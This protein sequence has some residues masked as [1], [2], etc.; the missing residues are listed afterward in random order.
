VR[1]AHKR[2]S[3]DNLLCGLIDVL[4]HDEPLSWFDA[5]ILEP[6]GID[7]FTENSIV[8]SGGR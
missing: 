7:I 4:E 6:F 1:R 5:E 2:V 3:M 8:L